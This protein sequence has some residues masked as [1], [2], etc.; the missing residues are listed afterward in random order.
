MKAPVCSDCH[1]AHAIEQPTADAFRMR[2]TPICGSCHTDK[3]STYRD[4]F[5]SQ[6]GALAATSNGTLL[7]LPR[8]P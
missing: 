5:H 8:R 1:T 7:G 4:T 2:S 3:F 6:L